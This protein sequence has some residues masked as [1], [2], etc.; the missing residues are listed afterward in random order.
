MVRIDSCPFYQHLY[1]DYS[2][3]MEMYSNVPPNGLQLM[4]I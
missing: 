1:E 4:Y 2:S 3:A